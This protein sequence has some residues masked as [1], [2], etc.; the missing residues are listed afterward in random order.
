MAGDNV[1][2]IIIYYSIDLLFLILNAALLVSFVKV[3]WYFINTLSI[4]HS[5][6]TSISKLLVI[7]ALI[8]IMI[9]LVRNF[10][11]EEVIK[12]LSLTFI[13]DVQEGDGFY[14]MEMQMVLIVMRDITEFTFIFLPIFINFVLRF[15][16]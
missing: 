3:S 14:S 2:L 6:N 7:I 10:V 15:F 1:F 5:F 11:I 9:G 13:K 12:V 16:A 4:S 8:L